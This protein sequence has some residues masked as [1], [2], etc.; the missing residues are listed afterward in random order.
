MEFR[1]SIN[2]NVGSGHGNGNEMN[3]QIK[4]ANKVTAKKTQKRMIVPT[5]TTM[6]IVTT[7]MVTILGITS[8]RS[9]SNVW[10]PCHYQN[11]HRT[12]HY[13]SSIIK[14]RIKDV[15]TKFTTFLLTFFK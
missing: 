5:K 6:M 7:T 12:I 15:P 9:L 3:L 10:N 11:K 13:T 1:S 4:P 8:M 2:I 14:W